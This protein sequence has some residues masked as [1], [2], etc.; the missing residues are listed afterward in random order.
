MANTVGSQRF[1]LDGVLS[2]CCFIWVPLRSDVP[3]NREASM[4]C[5]G[6][7]PTSILGMKMVFFVKNVIFRHNIELEAIARQPVEA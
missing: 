6:I 7:A 2:V 1:A 5:L 4:D 3:T